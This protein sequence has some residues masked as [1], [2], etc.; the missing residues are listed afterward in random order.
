[1]DE[2][3]KFV[4][5][6]NYARFSTEIDDVLSAE[7]ATIAARGSVVT[8]EILQNVAKIMPVE[9]DELIDLVRRYYLVKLGIA[10][11]HGLIRH[12]RA[13]VFKLR[14][15]GVSWSSIAD[16]VGETVEDARARFGDASRPGSLGF[17]GDMDD[18]DAGGPHH[19]SVESRLGENQ[20]TRDSPMLTPEQVA[21]IAAIVEGAD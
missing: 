20:F 2:E 17:F 7:A 14:Q 12:A 15:Y 5:Y 21:K 19:D 3:T 8:L 10:D 4:I 1:M 6:E 9:N 18:L 11:R 16:A 13:A